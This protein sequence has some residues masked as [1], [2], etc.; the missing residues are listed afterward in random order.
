[1]TRRGARAG[2]VIVEVPI[3]FPDRVRG[4]SKMTMGIVAEA[5]LAVSGWGLDRLLHR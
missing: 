4:T 2:G 3:V 5:M 1:M